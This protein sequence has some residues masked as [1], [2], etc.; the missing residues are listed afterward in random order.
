[1]FGRILRLPV[2]LVFE[3]VLDNPDVVNYD[4]YIQAL[5]RDMKEAMHV[6][7]ASALKQLKRHAD[8]YNRKVFHYSSWNQEI[9]F[10][11]QNMENQDPA[12]VDALKAS[13]ESTLE[14]AT[15]KAKMKM[16]Q[17][18][19]VPLNVAV[20]GNTGSGKSSFV[21]ALRG[22]KDDDVGAAPTG[23]TETTMAPVMYEHPEM[24]NVKIWDLPGIGSPNF[25]AKK[26]LKDVKFNTYDFFIILSSVRFMENDIMLAKEIRKQKKGFYF[27]CSKIDNDISSEKKKKGFDEQKVLSI[28]REDCQKNL[29]ELG[30]PKV[31]LISSHD[32]EEYDFESLQNILEDELP[33]HKKY[34]LLQAWPVCS[35]ASLEKKI[36]MFK[37]MIWA[38]SLASAATMS[39]SLKELCQMVN[40]PYDQSR[41]LI[42]SESSDG[43]SVEREE[44]T[45]EDTVMEDTVMEDTVVHADL[46]GGLEGEEASLLAPEQVQF[47]T[48]IGEW[49][50][51][52][53]AKE[54]PTQADTE[55]QTHSNARRSVAGHEFI[56]SFLQDLPKVPSHYCRSTTS[57]QYLEPVFQSMAD[58][59]AVYCRA[60]AEKNATPLSRQVFTDEFKR[61]NLGLYHPKKDQC[62]ICCA[63]KTGN[64]PDDEWQHHLLQKEEAR[65]E[66]LSD[67]NKASN[68]TMVLCMD[69]QALLLC[70]KLK[71]SALYYKTKLAVHNF[72]VYNM[73][74]HS[75]TCYVWHEGEGSLSA[76]EF[77]SCIVDYLSAH[78]EPDTFILWSDGCGYQNRNAVLSNALLQFSMKKNKVVIQKYLE[79]G[80]TQMECDSVHSVIERRL[81]DQ[82]VYLPA[83]YV[84]LMKKARVKPHPYEVKYIDHTFFQDFTK[85]RLCKS[86]RPGVRPGDP[87]VHDIRAIRYNNNGTMDFKINHSD[88]WHPHP[89]HQLRNST[90]DSHTVTPLYS[91]RLKINELKFKHLQDLKEVIPKDF[92]SFYNNL[93]H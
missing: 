59:Y 89:S 35:A 90:S 64:L 32:L 85:L 46:S 55:G 23:V 51:L 53:W 74:T 10:A 17:F 2:D 19:N 36:S 63:F 28:I 75:A 15:A 3:T 6:A 43:E 68:N 27:V 26:Y 86:L 92:H 5:R 69:L 83:E 70:P 14:K 54:G 24:P 79:K 93:L 62:N 71:A 57:K 58:L 88:D 87:T 30:D 81:R 80:H 60:A 67:K 21:N 50:A 37:W 82:D 13:G 4:S 20:T 72:T 66:K 91:D 12:V 52:N 49:S 48:G 16:D 47:D 8:L 84:N 25:K 11:I 31:F 73:L 18:F 42:E 78:T 41:A 1:M 77:A 22:L 76:S 7:Q 44:A 38:A 33:E 45:M 56:H 65:A 39:V 61:L 34:A 40:V 29:K 9:Q